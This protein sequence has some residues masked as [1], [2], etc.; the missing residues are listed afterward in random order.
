[1]SK[2]VLHIYT[3]V[4]TQAQQDEGTSLE[5]QKELG[6][7]KAK[8]LGFSYKVWNEGGASSNHEDLHNRPILIALLSEIENGKVSHLWVYNN[9]RLSRN[10]ITAQTIRVA[11][12]KNSVTL[13]TQNGKYDLNNPHDKFIKTVMDG[14]AQYDNTLRAERTRLGKV[15]RIKQGFWMGGPPPFG[16]IIE[17]KKLVLEP[18]ESKWVAR[19]YEWYSKNKST[20]WIKSELD[21]SGID[22]RRKRGSWSLGSIQKILQNTHPTGHYNYLDSKTDE[23]VRC[24]CPPI[25]GKALWNTCQKKRKEAFARRGQ[26]NRTK[27]FYLLRNLMYC[28][29]CGSPMSGRIKED[30]NEY[31]YY[32]PRKERAW[33]KSAPKGNDKW[34]R[35]TGCSMTRSLNIHATDNLVTNEVAKILLNPKRINAFLK[36]RQ[37]A[38]QGNE[39]GDDEAIEL[40]KLQNKQNRLAKEID[41]VINNIADVEAAKILGKQDKRISEKI[42]KNLNSVLNETENQLEVCN[43]RVEEIENKE[44]ILE[45]TRSVKYNRQEITLP[46]SKEW[47]QTSVKT[48]VERIDASYDKAKNE[49]CL[50]IRFKLPLDNGK[51]DMSVRLKKNSQTPA[52]TAAA[53]TTPQL[54]NAVTV[55]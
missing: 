10:E 7:Q 33:V 41:N 26:N 20:E 6:I 35:G 31:L 13:Y 17:N 27:R 12:Q 30:K 22:T 43:L 55:E 49:H 11:L 3:R 32:C 42:L 15:N 16:Y 4:S 36:E 47:I 34:K 24:S 5:S 29:H 25:I 37:K 48:C 50:N 1:M 18:E 46:L 44:D 2:N 39:S 19:I 38:L 54:D 40:K 23:V 8:E 21:K 53:Q 51:K 9:D 28:G 14:I 52:Q 45:I